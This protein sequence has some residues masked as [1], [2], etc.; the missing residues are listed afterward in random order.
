[1]RHHLA[2]D[3]GIRWGRGHFVLP[4]AT[5]QV[6]AGKTSMEIGI[7]VGIGIGIERKR[8]TFD[9]DSDSDPDP[10]KNQTTVQTT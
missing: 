6:I 9:S 3:D 8:I 2:S 10:E 1:M 5:T 7:R 4:L